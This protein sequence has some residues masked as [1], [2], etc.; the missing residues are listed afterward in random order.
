MN[1]VC[2]QWYWRNVKHK[3][4]IL[5]IVFSLCLCFRISK[6]YSQLICLFSYILVSYYEFKFV[7]KV[8]F[9]RGTC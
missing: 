1:L 8:S 3:K 9:K 2:C 5:F 4:N 6:Y 7:F